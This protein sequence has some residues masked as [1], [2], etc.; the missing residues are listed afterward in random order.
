MKDLFVDL[1]NKKP[2]EIINNDYYFNSDSDGDQFDETDADLWLNKGIFKSNWERAAQKDNVFNDM[3]SDILNVVSKKPSPFLEI[4]C[5]PAMGLTPVILSKYPQLPCLVSDACSLLI[6]SW[7]KY[8]NVELKQYDINL[9]SFSVMDMPMKSNCL[10]MVTS[11]L[12]VS[13]TRA[14]E[15]GEMQALSEIFRVLKNGGYFIA[16]ENEWTDFDAIEKVFA[17]W[18]RPVWSGIRKEK[19]WQE[20]FLECG[21]NIESCDKTYFRYLRKNDNDLGEQADK[22]GIKI[23][24]KFT[25]FI[26]RKP[27]E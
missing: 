24:T 10:D 17:L 19:T 7:R 11:S 4:A 18:G 8:I 25:L 20:K 23:G 12:G 14:G 1:F 5:G 21:F 16:I 27:S 2:L 13:S 26:L 9:A 22:F 15:Q 6:K 3:Y